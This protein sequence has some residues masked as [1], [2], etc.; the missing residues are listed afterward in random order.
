MNK[1]TI[2]KLIV[3]AGLVAVVG[4]A[5]FG[6]YKTYSFISNSIEQKKAE[7]IRIEEEKARIAKEEEA[8]R[9]EEEEKARKKIGVGPNG[10]A[11]AY[12]AKLVWDKLSKYDYSNNGEKIA[13]LT[14]DDGPSTT[15]TPKILDTLK[16]HDVKGTFFIVGS[17]LE[18]D[19]SK[20][21]LKQAYDEG[22]AIANHSYS[23][24]YKK[25]YPNRTLNLANF[26]DDI[27][28]TE[29][30]I[31]GVLGENF[32]T[33]V[34][35]CPGGFMSWKGMDELKTEFESK[36]MASIDWS[37]LN[38]DAEGRK[39]SPQELL[40]RAKSTVEGKELAVILMHDT[41]GKENTAAML[42]ELI[43]YLKSEG[44]SF[45]TLV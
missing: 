15:V 30:A 14:F 45:K 3:A 36:G 31:Q 34:V 40:Q 23:H 6:V 37:S 24:D 22:H 17:Q 8:K 13:F 43:T 10:E 39:K 18:N 41:Y 1:Y 33:N 16:K 28:K 32:L 4:G 5:G 21:L 7:N 29:K 11:Y 12:D 38:G 27:N 26:M 2:R 19:A 20:E 9:L 42:D 35:R 25:L 44:Y